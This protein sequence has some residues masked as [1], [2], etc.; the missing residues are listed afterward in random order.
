MYRPSQTPRLTMSSTWV[1]AAQ[2]PRL[3]SKRKLQKQQ[4]PYNRITLPEAHRPPRTPKDTL[5][6]M[7]RKQSRST[8]SPTALARIQPKHPAVMTE[9]TLASQQSPDSPVLRANPFPEVTDLICRL[10]LPTLFYRREAIHL[11]NLMRFRISLD[12]LLLSPRSAPVA[13]PAL[14]TQKTFNATTATLLHVDCC[15]LVD[16]AGELLHTP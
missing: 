3:N 14:I 8:S 13:A 11:E 15:W 4:S 9:S 7:H 12:Y 2:A 1:V 10:P 5:Q 6:T 16:S